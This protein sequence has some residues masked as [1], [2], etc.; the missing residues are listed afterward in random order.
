MQQF[1]A[2]ISE[3]LVATPSKAPTAVFST[4]SSESNSA[5][6]S[7]QKSCGKVRTQGQSVEQ[8]HDRP[9]KFGP[10]AIKKFIAKFYNG[11]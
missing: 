8:K 1:T 4:P 9:L 10:H 3:S 6:R 11:G 7:A 2:G 5:Q